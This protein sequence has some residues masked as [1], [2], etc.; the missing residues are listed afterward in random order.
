M[1]QF[2]IMVLDNT[3]SQ[4][5]TNKFKMD[6]VE[7]LPNDRLKMT[8][9]KHDELRT[10]AVNFAAQQK[11][12]DPIYAVYAYRYENGNKTMQIRRLEDIKKDF[13]NYIRDIYKKKA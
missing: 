13:S 7:P 1:M 5:Y 12:S 9:E 10:Y 3:K 4:L 8:P 11:V 2:V 6:G